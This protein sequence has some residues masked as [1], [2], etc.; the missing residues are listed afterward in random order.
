MIDISSNRFLQVEIS[1]LYGFEVKKKFRVECIKLIEAMR[2]LFVYFA[3]K[4]A[5]KKWL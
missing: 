2:K 3:K 1:L 4:T 5:K